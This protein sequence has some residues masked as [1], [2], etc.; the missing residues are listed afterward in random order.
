VSPVWGK[1]RGFYGTGRGSETPR[2]AFHVP[3]KFQEK[4][5]KNQSLKLIKTLEKTR[6][7]RCFKAIKNLEKPRKN[8]CLQPFLQGIFRAWVSSN[9]IKDWSML[10]K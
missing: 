10:Q 1:R 6:K 9:D 3:R 7:K 2:T 4:P 5:R 8:V